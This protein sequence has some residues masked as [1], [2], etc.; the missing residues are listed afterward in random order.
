MKMDFTPKFYD[1]NQSDLWLEHLD[2]EGYVVIKDI[3]TDEEK[4]HAYKLFTKD[5]Q[6]VSPNLDFQNPES[7][8]IQNVPCMF[9][10]GMAVFNGFG[11]SDAM[12]NLRTNNN[13]QHIFKAIH[14]TDELV[15][16]LDG[17][18]L[19]VSSEQKSKPWLHIDQNPSN[20]IYSIQG[21]YNLLPVT[22]ESAGF[23][24]IPQSH[25]MYKPEVSHKKNWIICENQQIIMEQAVK[26]IIP[27]NCLVLWNSKTIHSNIGM[28]IKRKSLDRI[29]AF[30]SY[31]P[32]SIR[33]DEIL[34]K[35]KQAYFEKKTT[36]HCVDKCEIKQY[37][38]GFK[39]NY[40]KKNFKSI[41]LTLDK[42]GT[43]PKER[44]ELL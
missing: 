7:F 6:T 5:I 13:I 15:V 37:P 12:W 38:W 22:N 42:D 33:N 19:F 26:L 35:R 8:I 41:N 1:K 14:K 40:E 16:S 36:S 30:L 27:E 21:A 2:N 23:V 31:Q 10:K 28:N 11:Q 43:I 20:L 25:K 17:F 9:G 18:S 32:K 39:T 24:I 44:L 34:K 4:T 3:L 29:T